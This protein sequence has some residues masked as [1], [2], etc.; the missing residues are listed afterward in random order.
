MTSSYLSA[1]TTPRNESG[2]PRDIET[3][4]LISLPACIVKVGRLSVSI[5]HDELI[6]RN[7]A[8][9]CPVGNR[10][11]RGCL[12]AQA[13]R[14]LIFVDGEDPP[15]EQRLTV[16]HEAAHFVVDYL[17]PRAQALARFGESIRAVLDAAREPTQEEKV[18]AFLGRVPLRAHV[19]LMSRLGDGDHLH[20]ESRADELAYEMLAPKRLVN[21]LVSTAAPNGN[22]RNVCADILVTRFG[23]PPAAAKDYASR[24]Y[25]HEP[26][27]PL[28]NLLGL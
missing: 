14:G 26:L 4:V 23:L 5:V 10:N 25:P 3:A 1:L 28:K 17:E 15:E 8:I 9:R 24:L 22:R 19:H 11:L 20:C 7:I 16:A 18:D 21:A 13:D 6:R 12:V 27:V 2:F